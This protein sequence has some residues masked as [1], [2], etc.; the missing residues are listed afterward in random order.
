MSSLDDL[1]AHDPRVRLANYK[2]EEAER[3]KRKLQGNAHR[4]QLLAVHSHEKED[5]QWRLGLAK[6]G[7]GQEGIDLV[8]NKEKERTR[9]HTQEEEQKWEKEIEQ[10]IDEAYDRIEEAHSPRT[11]LRLTREAL[12][13]KEQKKLITAKKIADKREKNKQAIQHKKEL[14]SLE[15]RA[16]HGKHILK[17]KRQHARLEAA[18]EKNAREKARI[19]AMEVAR[20]TAIFAQKPAQAA[21]VF[22]RKAILWSL[23]ARKKFTVDM[24]K[25]RKEYVALHTLQIPRIQR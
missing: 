6:A 11:Q 25:Q 22:A 7:M 18:M 13:L 10:K 5:L 9:K 19:L 23:K 20:V 1:P 12:E 4:E 3:K 16:N 21:Q 17:V 24:H 14:D 2:K 15:T 8:L